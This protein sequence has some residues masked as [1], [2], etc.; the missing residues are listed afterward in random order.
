[1]PCSFHT[2]LDENDRSVEEIN[3]REFTL[4]RRR[5]LASWL[6][7]ILTMCFSMG[8]ISL[9]M[10]QTMISDGVASAHHARSFANQICLLLALA[11]LLYCGKQCYVCLLY[12]SDLFAAPDPK[13]KTLCHHFLTK[14]SGKK[15]V[16]LELGIGS[17]NRLI[18]L[19]I[20]QLAYREMCI[21]DRFQSLAAS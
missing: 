13:K 11:N 7:A 14:Y 3:R 19:P 6:F 10:E 18:K 12:T 4:L 1:M 8:W 16:I 9:A 15:L 21:R 5:T 17:R 20:M 2:S